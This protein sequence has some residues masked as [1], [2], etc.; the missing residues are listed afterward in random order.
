MSKIQTSGSG[1]PV[2][3]KYFDMPQKNDLIVVFYLKAFLRTKKG[4]IINKQAYFIL[5]EKKRTA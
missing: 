4:Y 1:K 2:L 3:K 5:M